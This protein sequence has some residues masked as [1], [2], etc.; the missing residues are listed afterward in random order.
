MYPHARRFDNNT[1]AMIGPRKREYVSFYEI[2]L[3]REFK[4]LLFHSLR[5][6]M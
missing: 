2:I 4:K 3:Q 5:G 1:K 6:K